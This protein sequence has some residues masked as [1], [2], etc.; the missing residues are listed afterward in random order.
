MIPLMLGVLGS[1]VNAPYVYGDELANAKAQREK[2]KK[3]IADQRAAVARLNAMQV[4]LSSDI[5]RTTT[6]L[7]TINT[8]LKATKASIVKLQER[9]ALVTKAY[10]GLVAQLQL[11]D[12]QLV[13][14]EA[15]E[16]AKKEDLR[17][18][19]ALLAE[20]VRS[21]YDTDRTSPL[22]S[23]LSGGTFTD[24]LAEMSYYIDVA[25]QDKAL[26]E[27]ISKDQE[28]LAALHQTVEE[29][30][31]TTEELRK[32]TAAQKRELDRSMLEL[33]EA[34][35]RLKKLEAETARQ[36]KEQK[37]AYAELVRNKANVKKAIALAAKRQRELAA[38]IDRL[39]EAA[40]RRGNIPSI[41]NGKLRWPMIGRISGEYGC[42][43]YPGYAPGNGCAHYHN[44]IDIVAPSGTP[45]KAAG[46]GVV[47]FVGWNWADGADPA[48]I[49][50]IV[51]SNG[52][53]TWY[54]HMQP[55]TPKGIY[56]GATVKAGQVIG[57][58]GSTGNST[59]AHLHWMVELNG[60]F[61]NPRLFL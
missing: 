55:K 38:K 39:I 37:R 43:T 58:E 16:A 51:H 48:W 5:R 12:A 34:Q 10:D 57:Y 17:Q 35:A 44:G 49:V 4:G 60:S 18:R 1:P 26:A 29:T 45:I 46:A 6:E 42:S 23:F 54:A 40:G 14:V 30:R 36:L 33:K 61:T 25:E 53:K 47:G 27:Q 24:L 3:Q 31:V 21:A 50:V 9:I 2:I 56:A 11:L 59:G 20:R 41:Y 15:E 22:E 28:T 32:E 52:L 13:R 19:Q 7:R 8:D